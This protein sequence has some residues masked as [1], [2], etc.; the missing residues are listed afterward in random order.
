MPHLVDIPSAP[1]N[2]KMELIELLEDSIMKYLFNSKNDP[3]EIWK[4]AIDYPRLRH[5]A[6]KMLSCFPNH[7]LLRVNS[8]IYDTNQ[9]KVENSAY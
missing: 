8:L 7:L 4:N 3:H 9:N 6:Q 5:H 1:A 2:L